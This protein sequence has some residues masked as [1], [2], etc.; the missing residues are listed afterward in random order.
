MQVVAGAWGEFISALPHELNLTKTSMIAFL[1]VH[2]YMKNIG[3][4]GTL[5]GFKTRVTKA[6]EDI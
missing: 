6:L 4:E 1:V 2:A 5:D 3:E